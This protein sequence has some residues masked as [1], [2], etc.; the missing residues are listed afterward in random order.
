MSSLRLR[1]ARPA[2]VKALAPARSYQELRSHV[3]AQCHAQY[4][5]AGAGRVVTYP[6]SKGLKVEEIE[7]YY[8]SIG[9]SDWTHAETGA[10]VLKAQHPQFE[11]WSQ[12]IHARSGVACADCHMSYRRDGAQKISEHWVRSPLLSA[13]R[14]CATC[15]PYSDEELKA[16]VEA[17]H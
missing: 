13:N 11:M 7:S 5:L 1:A 8:D 17:I 4:Y 3:C 6:W 10:R 16:R 12:G 14:S 2:F 9:F 15:H